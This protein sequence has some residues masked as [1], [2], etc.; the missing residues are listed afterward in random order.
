MS[1]TINSLRLRRLTL[2]LI[3]PYRLSYRT[4]EEFEPIIVEVVDDQG[5]VGFG[6]GHI[7]P[8][9]SS[10]TR[11]GGWAF[12]KSL[13]KEFP[14]QELVVA[15][16][17]VESRIAESPVAATSLISA[18]EMLEMLPLLHHDEPIRLPLLAPVN[19]LE[20]AAIQSE[21]AQKLAM[22]FRT[23]KIKVGHDVDADL[24]RLELIQ[25]AVDGQATLRVDANRAYDG[26]SAIRFST[27]LSPDG[28]ELFEQPCAALDWD[29]NAQVASRSK[30]PLMLDEPICTEA[31][32]D[33]AATIDGVEFCKLKLKRFGG[34]RR[35]HDALVRVR[36][37][38]MRPVLGDGLGCEIACWME[39]CV[40]LDTIDNAGEFNGY[41][42]PVQRLFSSP[43]GFTQ[44]ALTMPANF[45]P[46]LNA[47]ML[48]AQTIEL[49]SV[50]EC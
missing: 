11:E 5:R 38:G 21:I 35:L 10:E 36:E 28:I 31:D 17:S 19:G 47:Q 3:T 33:R 20:A 7:S 45:E 50:G 49:V 27:E 22:G 48:A 9:S 25:R 24:R 2:P 44:G 37:Q 41:L 30:V 29:L 23:F 46:T 14:G 8:G 34:M 13:A 12:V 43:L 39:A 40:A 1:L 26:P 18:L 32:I 6:E 15:R 16:A 4:F 42:K